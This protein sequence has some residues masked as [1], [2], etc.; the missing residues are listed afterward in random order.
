MVSFQHSSALANDQ[1]MEIWFLH[2]PQVNDWNICRRSKFLQSCRTQDENQM[3][4][5]LLRVFYQTKVWNLE[6]V[7]SERWN[8]DQLNTCWTLLNTFSTYLSSKL[9]SPSPMFWLEENLILSIV[10]I[11]G[12]SNFED[13][14]VE[15][16]LTGQRL[17]FPKWLVTKSIL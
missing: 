13:K 5:I 6:Q 9:D 3:V 15:N 12:E 2:I 10:L 11:R 1:K 7:I 4:L 17:I 16:C 14:Y 8:S